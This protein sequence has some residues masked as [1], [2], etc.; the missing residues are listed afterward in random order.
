MSSLPQY[1]YTY[2]YIY[3]YIYI[4]LI[5][6][7]RLR[8]AHPLAHDSVAT[9]PR[10]PTHMIRSRARCARFSLTSSLRLFLPHDSL[11]TSLPGHHN[12]LVTLLP[13]SG[14]FV[15]SFMHFGR[16]PALSSFGHNI[17]PLAHSLS[18]AHDLPPLTRSLIIRYAHPLAHD[19]VATL[20]RSPARMI[21]SRA[22][23]ARFSLI[24][25]SRPRSRSAHCYMVHC[26]VLLFFSSLCFFLMWYLE[27]Q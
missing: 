18:L 26:N 19:S 4:S 16:S 15:H 12:S 13:G 27:V 2:I 14:R 20:L 3:N 6:H 23:C 8:Y 5:I 11:E 25:R 22:H 17:A 1:I 7:S 9:S 10:S 21:R 24:I